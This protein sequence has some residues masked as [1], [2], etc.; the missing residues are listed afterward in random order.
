MR[1]VIRWTPPKSARSDRSPKVNRKALAARQERIRD[2]LHLALAT[3]AGHAL[4]HHRSLLERLDQDPRPEAL[5]AEFPVISRDEYFFERERYLNLQSNESGFQRFDYPHSPLPRTA[6]LADGYVETE[7]VMCF[8]EGWCKDL[9]HFRA[10]CLAGP[11]SQLRRM[12]TSVLN[13]GAHFSIKQPLVAFT[14]L[15]FGDPGLLTD[16]VREQLWKAFPVPVYEYF[17]GHRHE[18]LARECGA[19]TG[20]HIDP[21]QAVFEIVDPERGELVITSLANSVFPAV[22]L[23]SGF[24]GVI[25]EE[26]C[27]CGFTG[28]RLLHLRPVAEK[29]AQPRSRAA[30]AGAS[31]PPP[32]E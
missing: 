9:E 11:V 21:V 13:R 10:E 2:L 30:M 5:L 32:G 24:T 29:L 4:P 12:A 19:H 17:L 27:A 15:P 16:A 6:I 26:P 31:S 22:R 18:V 7:K 3:P 8:P 25:T 23:G 14:G 1:V 20:L 28:Q